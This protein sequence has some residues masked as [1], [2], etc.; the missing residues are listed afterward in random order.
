VR[1]VV[2]S[3][4]DAPD[5]MALM[6][7]IWDEYDFVWEAETEVPDLYRFHEHYAPPHGAF[8]VVR[9]EAGLVV[10]SI[11]V[12]RVDATTSEIHRLYVD[13]HLRGRGI[14]RL[15]VEE[16]LAWSRAEGLR[17]IVLWS[18]TRFE[19]SHRLYRRLG[20]EQLGERTVPGDINASR[21]YRFERDL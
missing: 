6:S 20:F 18:D 7:R 3:I 9:D 5:V 21:E 8:W 11:G 4:A 13:G 15:L 2:A 19:Q 10:G 12:E 1:P 17:R 14:G 16:A